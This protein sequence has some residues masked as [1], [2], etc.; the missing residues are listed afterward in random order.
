[1]K[2]NIRNIQNFEQ[3]GKGD[4]DLLKKMEYINFVIKTNISFAYYWANN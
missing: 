2:K 4:W 3:P 1:M